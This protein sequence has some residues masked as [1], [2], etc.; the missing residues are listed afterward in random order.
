MRIGVVS[1]T[2]GKAHLF[3]EAVK[4]MGTVDLLIHAGDHFSDAVTMGK[5]IGIKL[6]AVTGNC[7]WHDSGPDE[8]ELDIMGY[9]ILVT[10]GHKYGVKRDNAKL[11][12]K[13]REGKYNLIVYGHSHFPEITR[14]ADG[15]LLNPGSVSFP[16]R[17][18]RCSYAIVLIDKNGILPYIH[19]LNWQP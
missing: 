18:S 5:E 2:H 10:H 14:L 7:D 3:R 19:E 4:Q 17:G 1:D 12:K 9:K 13:L 6:V 16:R 15:I 11:I 8:E